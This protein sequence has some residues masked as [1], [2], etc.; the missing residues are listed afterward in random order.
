LRVEAQ[1]YSVGPL[2]DHAA[3]DAAVA[4]VVR[5]LNDISEWRAAVEEL[6]TAG[7]T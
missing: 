2:L 4:A 3:R 1:L 6:G 5:K 7:D